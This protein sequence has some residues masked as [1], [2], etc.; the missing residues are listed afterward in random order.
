M[1]RGGQESR[2]LGIYFQTAEHVGVVHSY[3]PHS[4]P[5]PGYIEEYGISDIENVIIEGETGIPREAGVG[6]G[7][8]RQRQ[9]R[10]GGWVRGREGIQHGEDN[11]A[12]HK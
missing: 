8:W 5:M 2:R 6:L 9:G 4:G 10:R 11:V 3:S 7:K 12:I 1:R